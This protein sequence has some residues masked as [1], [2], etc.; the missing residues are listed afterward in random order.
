LSEQTEVDLGP[1]RWEGVTKAKLIQGVAHHVVAQLGDDRNAGILRA[2][3]KLG[4]SQPSAWAEIQ[5]YRA[6]VGECAV[7]LME[8]LSERSSAEN[9]RTATQ[10]V[11]AT[12]IDAALLDSRPLRFAT[13]RMVTEL[14]ELVARYLGVADKHQW[15][16]ITI[17]RGRGL[18]A[19]DRRIDSDATGKAALRKPKP[20]R[21]S[22]RAM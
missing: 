6:T 12:V 13:G 22:I 20:R 5:A 17:D 1:S 21:K 11:C 14:S 15:D 18:A 9:V 19:A 10:I 7:K 2:A 16:E 4:T 3:I 8:G